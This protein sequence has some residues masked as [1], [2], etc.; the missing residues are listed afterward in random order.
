MCVCVILSRRDVLR[1]S[2]RD[3]YEK[4]RGEV[5][6]AKVHRLVVSGRDALHKVIDDMVEK[7][8]KQ[9]E[10]QAAMRKQPGNDEDNYR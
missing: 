8:R 6:V 4:S 1:R 9:V 3:E 7:M 5:D 10:Q 2:A